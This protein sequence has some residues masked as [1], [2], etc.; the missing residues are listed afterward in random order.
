MQA[1]MKLGEAVYKTSD[2][3]QAEPSGQH[4]E[5]D[6]SAEKPVEGEILDAE[7]K[8]VDDDKKHA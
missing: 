6:H 3:Q 8:D 7:F 4:T 2:A 1:S 5:G